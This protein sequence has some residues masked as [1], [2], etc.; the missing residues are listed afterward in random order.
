MCKSRKLPSC[1]TPRQFQS[2]RKVRKV[3]GAEEEPPSFE[4]RADLPVHK[5]DSKGEKPIFVK[6]SVQGQ[7]LEMEVDMGSA[8]SITSDKTWT[9]HFPVTELEESNLTLTTYT[10]E[11]MKMLRV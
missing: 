8:V 10:D 3:E 2:Q 5:L 11:K 1:K 7:K 6:V 4:K 9:D